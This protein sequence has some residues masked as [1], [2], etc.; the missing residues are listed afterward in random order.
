MQC[1]QLPIN[2]DK[3]ALTRREAHQKKMAEKVDEIT[4]TDIGQLDGQFDTNENTENDEMMQIDSL[5]D[6]HDLVLLDNSKIKNINFTSDLPFLLT[7]S[8]DDIIYTSLMPLLSIEDIFRIRGTSSGFRSMVD[9]YFAQLKTLDLTSI[10]SRFTTKAF[11]VSYLY[12]EE[13]DE[14]L[15]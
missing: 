5:E 1:G 6:C 13:N 10:G 7:L 2:E 8:W 14:P 3:V 9:E 4:N 12:L 15:F 11:K